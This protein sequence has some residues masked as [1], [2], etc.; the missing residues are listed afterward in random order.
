MAT[1]HS[2]CI[3]FF[4]SA[5]AQF[6]RCGTLMREVRMHGT[7]AD[8]KTRVHVS[9]HSAFFVHAIMRFHAGTGPFVRRI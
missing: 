3:R 7:S 9:D 5:N 1:V 2:Q 4:R 6:Y 8:L